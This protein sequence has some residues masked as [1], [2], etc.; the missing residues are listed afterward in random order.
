MNQ[1]KIG[2]FIA[3][4][5]KKANLTQMQL[6]EKLG[7]TDKAVSKW[8]RGVAMPDTSIMLELCEILG[9][10]CSV[11]PD[12]AHGVSQN[13]LV[14]TWQTANRPSEHILDVTS[15]T[16]RNDATGE[17]AY[18]HWSCMSDRGYVQEHWEQSSSQSTPAA[19]TYTLRGNRLTIEAKIYRDYF[20]IYQYTL[21]ILSDGS[22]LMIPEYGDHARFISADSAT[23]L[24]QLCSALNV[25]LT[26]SQ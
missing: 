17:L 14:G 1:I 7:I 19:Y 15:Y 12:R 11:T 26:L 25:D 3:E 9:I 10:S 16:F 21:A 8:E 4:C 24:E 5:R 2:R 13:K 22:L 18:Q 20:S 6:A 23:T